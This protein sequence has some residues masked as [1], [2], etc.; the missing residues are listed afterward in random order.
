MS[1]LDRFLAKVEKTES[2]WIWKAGRKGG[3][4]GIF[5][6][7]GSLRGAHRVA[8]ELFKGL[9]I[10]SPLDAMHSCDNPSCVNPEHLRYGT[11]TENMRDCSKKGRIKRVQ[12][13]EGILN[14][15][16]KL[17]EEQKTK[18]EELCECGVPAREVAEKYGLTKERVWQIWKAKKL[19]L[20][21]KEF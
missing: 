9:S 17:T 6:F 16:A 18:I 8:L 4:Y 14:P 13:W 21:G 11:K 12:C 20:A 19:L 1:D 7:K 15:K 2:C 3:G 10:D 5:W